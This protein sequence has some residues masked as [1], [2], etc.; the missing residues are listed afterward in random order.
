[1]ITIVDVDK[2]GR[3]VFPKKLRDAMQIIPGTRLIMEQSGD[4]VVLGVMHSSAR[5][6]IVDGTPLIFPADQ[7]EPIIFT[8]E[9]TNELI[10][11]GRLARERRILGL[12][13][14]EQKSFEGG[15]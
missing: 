13:D 5:L 9:M 4:K 11:D 10:S 3:I 14:D 8:T 2:L 7:E 15:H 12:D 1:M 6:E